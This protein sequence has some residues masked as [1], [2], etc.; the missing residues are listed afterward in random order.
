MEQAQSLDKRDVAAALRTLDLKEFYADLAFNEIGQPMHDMSVLQYLP[1]PSPNGAGAVTNIILPLTDVRRL[2]P[3]FDLNAV[4]NQFAF[5]MPTYSQRRCQH[6]SSQYENTGLGARSE[7]YGNGRCTNDGVCVCETVTLDGLKWEGKFC[8]KEQQDSAESLLVLMVVLPGAALLIL[9]V[10][11]F[12]SRWL[13]QRERAK[14]MFLHLKTHQPPVL[15]MAADCR[16][17]FFISHVWKTGQDQAAVIKRLLLYYL[18]GPKVFLDVDDLESTSLIEE[19]IAASEVVILFISKHYFISRNCQREVREAARLGKKLCLIHETDPTKGG[20]SLQAAI[21]ECPLT[22]RSPVF[23]ITDPLQKPTVEVVAWHRVKMFQTVSLQHILQCAI[24]EQAGMPPGMKNLGMAKSRSASSNRNGETHRRIYSRQSVTSKQIVIK[25]YVSIYVSQC[26]PGVHQALDRLFERLESSGDS[27][28]LPLKGA[29]NIKLTRK[30][31]HPEESKYQI[32]LSLPFSGELSP[33]T[34]EQQKAATHLQNAFR[35]KRDVTFSN[36]VE[37]AVQALRGMKWAP[38]LC[39]SSP[40]HMLL[41]LNADTFLGSAGDKLAEETRHAMQQKLPLVLLHECDPQHGSC[42]FDRFFFSTPEDIIAMG[43]FNPLAIPL[44]PSKHALDVAAML[45]LKELA[46]CTP[47]TQ[48]P[49]ISI[50]LQPGLKRD[51]LRV[52]ADVKS[53]AAKPLSPIARSPLAPSPQKKSPSPRSSWIATSLDSGANRLPSPPGQSAQSQSPRSPSRD[54][55]G[56]AEPTMYEVTG[57]PRSSPHDAGRQAEP[58]EYEVTAQPR[59]PSSD[60][61][62]QAEPTAYIVAAQFVR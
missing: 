32:R 9:A 54:A 48:A 50:A 51:L 61:G 18:E 27:E 29:D 60:A 15:F 35:R 14:F 37:R 56:Q 42:D 43:I 30:L 8:N 62:R 34:F 17:H 10:G 53:L 6:Q 49:P 20:L 40:T 24:V 11:R 46:K 33:S 5:P 52:R 47:W 21:E 3:P 57:Q 1:N 16:W 7:C 23:G 36:I 45:T 22:M 41:Y 4:S 58:A 38:A 13:E 59:S 44:H 25:D 28:D 12:V 19:Y 2:S 26:N 31:P 55:D 39:D